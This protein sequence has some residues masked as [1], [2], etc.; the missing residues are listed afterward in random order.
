ML[1]A[2]P[3]QLGT[4]Q[5]MPAKT[6]AASSFPAQTPQQASLPS[7]PANSKSSVNQQ[8]SA[9]ENT[10]TNNIHQDAISS[11]APVLPVA[12]SQ[13][14]PVANTPN[15]AGTTVN[16]S[17]TFVPQVVKTGTSGVSHTS[18]IPPAGRGPVTVD[19]RTQQLLTRIQS[20]IDAFKSKPSLDADAKK[21]LLQ[22]QEAQQRVL[23]N[24]RNQAQAHNAPPGVMG[25]QP[26]PTNGLMGPGQPQPP[27]FMHP[28]PQFVRPEMLQSNIKDKQLIIKPG[29]L[30]YMLSFAPKKLKKNNFEVTVIC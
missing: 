13:T 10:I 15:A 14:M 19:A 3:I 20:Q 12:S 17:S 4:V 2:Q 6:T 30:R 8:P 16:P 26:R 21:T 22:L 23:N 29:E 25:A 5:Q 24:V 11:A 18:N 27:T 1:T 7:T 9:S 28:S